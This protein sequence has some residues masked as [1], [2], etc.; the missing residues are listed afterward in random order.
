MP[1]KTQGRPRELSD[2]ALLALQDM[3]RHRFT[4]VEAARA[5]KI[6]RQRVYYYY[7]KFSAQSLEQTPRPSLKELIECHK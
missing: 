5:L 3:F 6:S 2:S 7:Q 4:P 1:Y